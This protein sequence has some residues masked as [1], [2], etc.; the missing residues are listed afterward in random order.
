MPGQ[1]ALVLVDRC[2]NEKVLTIVRILEL[3]RVITVR[4]N[5]VKMIDSAVEVYQ[6]RAIVLA[7]ELN[8]FLGV[9]WFVSL[10]IE[11]LVLF[12]FSPHHSNCDV[13]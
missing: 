5:A 3:D 6:L 11:P 12:T 10:A 1:G 13:I 4:S 8:D 2:S 7:N 9:I